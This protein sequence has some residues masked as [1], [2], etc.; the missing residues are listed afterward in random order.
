MRA[1]ARSTGARTLIT[2]TVRPVRRVTVDDFL[3]RVRCHVLS[4]D[5]YMARAE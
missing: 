4:A 3:N 2:V 1:Y 5:D